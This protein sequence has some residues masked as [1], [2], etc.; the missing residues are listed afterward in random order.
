MKDKISAVQSSKWIFFFKILAVAL[1]TTFYFPEA[2]V[3]QSH[4]PRLIR[5]LEPVEPLD[6]KQQFTQEAREIPL[7]VEQHLPTRKFVVYGRGKT[8]TEIGI[9]PHVDYRPIL[10]S[11]EPE[12]NKSNE[13]NLTRMPDLETFFE[14][15]GTVELLTTDTTLEKYDI[16]ISELMWGSDTGLRDTTVYI[17]VNIVDENGNT[18]QER[19][20]LP[21]LLSQEVQW[22]EL[23]NTTT[24]DI[25]AELYFLFTPFVSYPDRDTVQLKVADYQ[26]LDKDTDFKVLDAVSNLLFG[27]W[28]LPG[29]SGRRPSTAFVS[30]Y[31]NIDYDVVE[32]Y[33]L[34]RDTQLAGI[35]F[36]SY[37]ESWEKTS[38]EGRRNTELKIVV[39]TSVV[40]L[41][42]I[43]T[44]G[45]RHVPEVYIKPLKPSDVDADSVIINEVRNDTSRANVDWIELKNVG[46]RTVDLE[47]WELS[48][49]TAV[50]KD[51]DL[52][53]LPAYDLRRGEILLIVNQYPYFTDLAE[54]IDIEEPEEHRRLTG[55]THKYFVS[56]GLDFPKDKKF[57]LLLRSKNDRNGKDEA[58]EDY[59][60]NGFFTD[61]LTTEFWP[62]VA[63]KKPINVADFGDNTFASPDQAWARI[64]YEEDDGHHEEAWEIVE[65]QGGLG[66]TAG[67]DLEYA[68]GTPGYENTALKTRMKDRASPV[69]EDEY[70]DGEISISEIMYDPG[71][72]Q[73]HVQW[74]ELYNSSMTQSINLEG[75][76]L[77]IRNLSDEGG[78]YVNGS[79]EFEEATILPNQTL[80]L[81][82]RKAATDLPSNR[83]YDLY[84]IHRRDLGL[85]RPDLLLSPIAFYLKLTDKADPERDGD[86]IVVDEVGNLKI[87]PGKHSKAWDLPKMKPER[88]RSIVRLYGGLFKPEKGGLDG[89]PSPPDKGMSAKGWRRFTIKGQSLS[90]YGI[91]DDLASPGYRMGGPLPVELSSF[92][93][94]RMETGEVL[95][96]WRTESE[97]NNA[98]FNILRSEK[99]NGDFTVINVKGIIPGQGTSSEM[100]TYSYTDTTA[101]PDVIYYY[102]IED[103]S[104]DGVCQT[105]ATVRLRGQVSAR[106]KLT[107][108]WGNLKEQN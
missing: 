26:E 20:Y 2:A 5:L 70:D 55:L 89:K 14:F 99:R 22:I 92:R 3:A 101:K 102:R 12:L 108:T 50:G 93:P 58:I 28:D 100:H 83:V 76:E 24:E 48:I 74:I 80:L 16:V 75:W 17:T 27:K 13:P 59:A 32:D 61:G 67:A 107:T 73:K 39:R 44:P 84:R 65:A 4:Q 38:D 46:T 29:K 35:P 36:G 41:P 85:T 43:A 19:V 53:V 97:L 18:V 6:A 106:G 71:P 81:V 79:F 52:V 30:A 11:R 10:Y 72:N 54:G 15:G 34:L 98:G 90:F 56:D 87:E 42:Y 82:A 95:I 7:D 63:Q 51:T 60:G 78:T 105:L 37:E 1:V 66:Y 103:V 47:D 62:R 104:F 88:R 9:V 40:A 25:T 33:T 31:R 96:K 64:R 23:Y 8:N 69:L 21:Q 49:V 86:D 45:T 77:E 57:T 68:P 91:R 94:V